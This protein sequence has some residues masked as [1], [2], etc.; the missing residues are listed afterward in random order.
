M[1]K[2]FFQKAEN[3][4]KLDKLQTEAAGDN[5]KY[6]F[7]VT[8]LLMNEV[9]PVIAHRYGMQ[10]DLKGIRCIINEMGR[11]GRSELKL[12]ELWYEVEVL[13]RNKN[14]IPGAAAAVEAHR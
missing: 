1:Q 10:E 2:A 11:I 9:Y 13:M 8:Q 5:A 12:S 4:R 3:Q 6:G 7:A 14:T